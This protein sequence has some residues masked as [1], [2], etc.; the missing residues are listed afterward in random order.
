MFACSPLTT[1]RK[2]HAKG[3]EHAFHEM[4]SGIKRANAH[5]PNAA[6]RE[7]YEGYIRTGRVFM[8]NHAA[9]AAEGI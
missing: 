7:D 6:V 9:L 2:V 3:S 1:L 4:I 8:Q 5:F